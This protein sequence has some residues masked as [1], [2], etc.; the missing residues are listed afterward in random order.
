MKRTESCQVGY[1]S[2]QDPRGHEGSLEQP[3]RVY[4]AGED[5]PHNNRIRRLELQQVPNRVFDQGESFVS[6]NDPR[7]ENG[8]N[9]Y[10]H[11]IDPQPSRR[12]E[13]V[14]PSIERDFPDKQGGQTSLHGKT[15]Q[16]NPFG[17]HQ[18]LNRGTQRLPAPS[19]INLD[20]YEELPSSKRR[21]VDDQQ[22]LDSHSQGRTILVPI[23]QI[24]DRRLRYE[25]PHGNVHRDDTGDFV[26]DKRIVPLPPKEERVR[27]PLSHQELQLFSPRTQ[28]ER[29]PD[30]VADR[31]E[32][33]LQPRDHYRV[34]LSHP[35]NV[36]NLQ[37]PSRAVFAPPE[38][39]NDSSSFFDSSRFASRHHDSSDLGFSSRH[40]A[41]VI[42][43]SDRVYAKP[44]GM[45]RR[46]Q[47]LEVAEKSV[48]SRFSNM[49]IDYRQRDNDR[50]PDHISYVPLTATADS[51][52]HTRPST[53]ALTS[54][55]QHLRLMSMDKL[56]HAMHPLTYAL[57]IAK[58]IFHED[59]EPPT[60]AYP[61]DISK[62]QPT[63]TNPD[64]PSRIQ[65]LPGVQHQ[66]LWRARPKAS[67]YRQ[68]NPQYDEPDQDN[69]FERREPPPTS[70]AVMEAWSV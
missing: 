21:R 46:L 43:D 61:Y 37:F 66:P 60:N 19:V 53:G 12:S 69:P 38:Y 47:P 24:D 32:R 18:A 35:Q 1:S 59:M 30:Q 45:M 13:M 15:R 26:S 10:A 23:E 6:Q 8:N 62:R 2:Q 50:M 67:S 17:S 14:L 25:R 70:R 31:G 65:P 63:T 36:E 52:R 58:D 48:P 44:D 64:P 9:I 34:P 7:Q 3:K 42:A 55:L 22:P 57:N 33:Y 29:C 5:Q 20:D 4:Y 27:P 49:S 54:L 28:L 41:G 56:I 11:E 51:H 68:S 16:L 39:Y 40:D